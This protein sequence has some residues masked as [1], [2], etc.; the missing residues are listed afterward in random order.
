M[1]TQNA[2]FDNLK[3]VF[4]GVA[5]DWATEEKSDRP[6]LFNPDQT[7]QPALHRAT[8]EL[9]GVCG[10]LDQSK[11]TRLI[12]PLLQHGADPYALYRQPILKSRYIRLY[13]GQ[14]RDEEVD[15]EVTDL[16]QIS[17]ARRGIIEK[18]LRL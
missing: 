8:G 13:P 12:T 11:A 1:Y 3:S 7:E 17:F 5:K 2:R 9:E 14:T 18:A 6:P 10:Y 4:S 15:D 16:D